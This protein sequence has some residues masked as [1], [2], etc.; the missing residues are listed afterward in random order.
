[1]KNAAPSASPINYKIGNERLIKVTES[2]SL[3]LTSLLEKQGRPNGALRVAVIGGGCSGLQYK[4]D[5][6]DGPANRDILVQTSNVRVVVDPKS[7]LFVSGSVLDFSDDLQ[8]GGFK[9]TNPNAVAHCS[10]GESF[11]A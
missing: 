11:A 10:C 9:V 4:M 6:V 5:L 8:K 3:K 1:M 2:A 7:A